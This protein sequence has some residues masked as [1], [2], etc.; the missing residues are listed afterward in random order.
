MKICNN[1]S[2]T[3]DMSVEKCTAC[4]MAGNFTPLNGKEEL[5][6]PVLSEITCVNCGN[7]HVGESAHC[8]HCRFPI[9]KGQLRPFSNRTVQ[10]YRK[11][12]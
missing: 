12:G 8:H 5:P 7:T 4:N 6:L 1:C 3:N 10:L 9:N 2:S 11:V